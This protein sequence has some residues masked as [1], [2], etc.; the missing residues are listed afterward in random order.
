MDH[1]LDLGRAVEQ[2]ELGVVVQV[3]NGVGMVVRSSCY[4]LRVVKGCSSAE[5]FVVTS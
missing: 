4:F 1:V 3:T 2:G 5:R